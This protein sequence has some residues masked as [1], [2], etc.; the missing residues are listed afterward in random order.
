MEIQNGV[1]RASNEKSQDQTLVTRVV[2]GEHIFL[3]IE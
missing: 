3:V 2:N 1:I